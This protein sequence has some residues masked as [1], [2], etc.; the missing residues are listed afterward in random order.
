MFD[1]ITQLGIVCSECQKCNMSALK[2]DDK[3]CIGRG[4]Y[5][6]KLMIV[7]PQPIEDDNKL[8]LPLTGLSGVLLEN[9]LESVEI[10]REDYY[11]TTVQKCNSQGYNDPEKDMIENCLPYLEEQI[12]LINPSVILCMG[13]NTL[14]AITGHKA[15]ITKDRGKY[16][17]Y[18]DKLY[19]L[20]YH[21]YYLLG[22]PTTEQGKPKYMTWLDLIKLKKVLSGLLLPEV[23]ELKEKRSPK[24]KQ[25]KEKNIT[26][27]DVPF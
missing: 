8:G 4:N 24:T 1:N 14:Q 26:Y 15:Q 20:T 18:K 23:T 7:L 6:S 5:Y 21:P 27:D 17:S 10:E 9:M 3:V 19:L 25:T 2:F 13:A 11:L 22:H 16:Y 12:R